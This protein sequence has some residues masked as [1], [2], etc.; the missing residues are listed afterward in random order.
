MSI[1]AN[2]KKI[3]SGLANNIVL[4][5]AVKY[6]S[7]EQIKELVNAGVKDLGF[8]TYQ[9]MDELK[10]Q[11]KDAKLHFI[12]HLQS[13]KVKKVLELGVELIQ[14]VE[15]YKLAEKIN[16]ACAELG[17][18]Q[19]ILLQVNTDESK[20]Y[21]IEFSELQDT[22]LK[23]KENLTNISV[24]GLMTIPPLENPRDYFAEMKTA[25]DQLSDFFDFKYLSM[26]MSE[27]YKEAI[28]EGASMIRIGRALFY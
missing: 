13:N 25:Y 22:A 24:V 1:Q 16:S 23:I 4:V 10:S 26:G 11:L 21:G 14:S 8:N 18:K 15:S 7:P 6:A 17:I 20:D 28:E 9:Q 12:G 27:D 3:K 5:A 2:I 19:D